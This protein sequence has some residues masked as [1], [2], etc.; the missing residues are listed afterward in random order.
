[1]WCCSLPCFG[2]VV[3]CWAM[4]VAHLGFLFPPNGAF[5]FVLSLF[6]QFLV[7]EFEQRCIPRRQIGVMLYGN[8]SV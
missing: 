5:E 8:C 3:L 7:H 4:F 2:T 6:I 1:V